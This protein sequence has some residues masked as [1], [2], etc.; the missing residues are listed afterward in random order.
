[1]RI[2]L[3][4]LATLAVLAPSPSSS[5]ETLHV[6]PERGR[7]R[8]DGSSRRPLRTIAAAVARLPDPL[9]DAWTI[10]LAAGTYGSTGGEGMPDATLVLM[11]RML[12]GATVTLRG[13]SPDARAVLAWEG[14]RR[15]VHATEGRWHLANLQVG[16]FSTAQRRGVEVEGTAEVV[17][18]DVR[19]RIR[20]LSGE[21]IFATRGGRATLR[22]AI[23]LNEHLHD[24]AADET[25]CGILATDHGVVA[26]DRRDGATLDVGNGQLSCRYYGQIRLGCASAR[27]TSWTTG[28]NLAVNSSG[29]I[30][31]LGTETTLV[32]KDPR[33]TPIGL[34]HDGHVLAEDAVIH[35]RGEN[36]SAIALQ[37][38][39]TFTC[40][41]VDLDGTFR[42]AL[43]ASSGSMFVGRFLGDV[44]RLEA[45]TGARILVEAVG[46]EVKGPVEARGGG[47]VSLPDR[48][49]RGE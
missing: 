31:L 43:W 28:N 19:F 30:D 4:L 41:D 42:H 32:A 48:V 8:G 45:S 29:R 25:F 34:E 47:V 23:E 40:N 38:A 39:S 24:D 27:I 5:A 33:N 36:H 20:S 18:E 44:T 13:P 10:A 22:G 3:A 49:V 11:R 7:D 2:P 9:A 14:E 46:G 17:L 1:M 12:P 15:L 37:K 16:T 35:V 6:D 21:G 26:F